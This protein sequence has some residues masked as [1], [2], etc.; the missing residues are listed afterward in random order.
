MKF[1]F[2]ACLQKLSFLILSFFVFTSCSTVENRRLP[3][4]VSQHL[5]EFKIS[6]FSQPDRDYRNLILDNI[7][8][9]PEFST[10]AG[11]N[12]ILVEFFH[13]PLLPKGVAYH[14]EFKVEDNIYKMSI[15]YSQ[16]ALSDPVATLELIHFIRIL[17]NEKYFLSHF[18]A[19][20]M[21]F[22]AQELDPEATKNW[23]TIR[24]M[25]AL[26]EIR[27]KIDDFE[28]KNALK[29]RGAEWAL[30][31][32]L[33]NEK[34]K[35]QLKLQRIQEN[36]R[37]HFLTALD[38]A[39][40]DEQLKTLIAK[41]DR[42][43]AAHLLNKY[44]PWEQMAPF[45]KKYWKSYLEIIQSPL[46]FDQRVLIFRGND[47]DFIYPAIQEGKELDKQMAKKEGQ[48][49]LMSTLLTRNQGSWNRRLRSLT[50]M[51]K[52]FIGTNHQLNDE[53][54]KSARISS[55]FFNHSSTPEGSPFLSFTPNFY[56]AQK[57][58]EKKIS[59]YVIDPRLLSFNFAS[60]YSQEIEFLTPLFIFPEDVVAYTEFNESGLGMNE[61][62]L[63]LQFKEK[64]TNL[65]GSQDGEAIFNKIVKNSV[66]YF[67]PVQKKYTKKDPK[68]SLLDKNHTCIDLISLFW[69]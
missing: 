36:E 43:G 48:I 45:E 11:P 49:F 22:N 31:K 42:H 54:T 39:T 5:F 64:L 27:T 69:N 68:N 8:E 57:F 2:F 47:D 41:N 9:F 61:L 3:A 34:V 24:E 66:D 26:L 30:E 55:I 32:D 18:S 4:N 21:Y 56:S 44:L 12:K 15:Y 6:N 13:D 29:K 7:S 23:A 38:S 59:A 67:S 16:I 19:F 60:K 62:T 52:K 1:L 53:F 37:R 40:D 28:V 46:P 51:Y 25:A 14:P 50:T 10:T 65:H 63:K 20:E 33:Y 17:K 58:G 35:I